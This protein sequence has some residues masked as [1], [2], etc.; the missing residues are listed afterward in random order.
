MIFFKITVFVS[1]GLVVIVYAF[2]SMKK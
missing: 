1:I 2:L